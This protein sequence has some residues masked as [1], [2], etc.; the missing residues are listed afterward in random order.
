MQ[1]LFSVTALNLK[2]MGYCLAISFSVI[3]VIEIV[4]LFIPKTQD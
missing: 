3:P 4:K 2:Q 1:D